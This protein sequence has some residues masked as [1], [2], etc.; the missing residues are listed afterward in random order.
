M[1]IE[2]TDLLL[3]ALKPGIKP[4]LKPSGKKFSYKSDDGACETGKAY[5]V[6]DSDV[7]G[8]GIRVL[9]SGVMSFVLIG[10]FP[11]SDNPVR[12]TLGVY[13]EPFL[14]ADGNPLKDADGKPLPCTLALARDKAKQW[15]ALRKIGLDPAAE[16]E[17][18]R[19]EEEKRRQ[20]EARAEKLR[21]ACTFQSALNDYFEHKAGLR[22]I[23]SLRRDMRREFAHWL[24][25]PLMDITKADI[26]ETIRAIKPRGLAQAKISFG[27]LRRFL[28]WAADSGDYALEISPCTGIKTSVLIGGDSIPRTRVLSDVELAAYWRAAEA[29]SYPAGPFCKLLVLSACRRNEVARGQ[30]LEFN[31][32]DKLWVIPASRMK[33]KEG[34]AAAHAVPLTDDIFAVLESLPRFK[35]GDFLFSPNGGRGALSGFSE[36]KKA[37]DAAMHADLE[38]QGETFEA[39]TLHDIRRTARTRFSSLRIPSE[40]PGAPEFRIQ[41]EV[42]EALLAHAKPGLHKT[43]NLYDYLDEKREALTAW[44]T[45]L[46]GIVGAPPQ[47]PRGDSNVLPFAK[48]G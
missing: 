6:M 41:T 1:K 23:A 4:G 11:G 24:D 20:E 9:P 10:R 38:A 47:E 29:M 18:K 21:Q 25:T 3:K 36:L 40:V 15:L 17:R 16:I 28:D 37:L 27:Q 26:K 12:R 31:L 19:K 44:H 34:K 39:F 5:E 2:L 45:V 43:Y 30:W 33:G 32:K 42:A 7:H 46:R 14:D 8:F 22:S 35:G 48:A 13:G